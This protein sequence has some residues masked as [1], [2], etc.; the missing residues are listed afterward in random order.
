[1]IWWLLACG[2][3]APV[4]SSPSVHTIN[5][6]S[7][8]VDMGTTEWK[9]PASTMIPIYDD[10]SVEF[11]NAQELFAQKEYQKTAEILVLLYEKIQ[12]I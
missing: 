1:M 9:Y 11:R 3:D 5:V 10:D 4:A 6:Q 2:T 8:I 12:N 7:K